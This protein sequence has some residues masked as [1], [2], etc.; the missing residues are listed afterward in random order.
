V[1]I[2]LVTRVEAAERAAPA[3][4]TVPQGPAVMGAPADHRGRRG[5]MGP[6]DARDLPAAPGA[7]GPTVTPG[8][9]A[10]PVATGPTA[11]P[12]A[13]GLSATTAPIETTGRAT[14]GPSALTAPSGTAAMSATAGP[15]AVTALTAPTALT[16]TAAMSATAG[17]SAVSAPTALTVRTVVT[18]LQGASGRTAATKPPVVETAP[19]A[20]PAPTVVRG[21]GVRLVEDV[22]IAMV[23]V[24]ARAAARTAHAATGPGTGP[25]TPAASAVTGPRSPASLLAPGSR[26]RRTSRRSPRGWTRA[27]CTAPSVPSCAACRRTWPRSSPRTWWSP[28]S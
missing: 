25:R 14:A 19:S 4:L 7:A 11:M 2:A 8:P 27:S 9:T 17:P 3:V 24:P 28:V 5:L 15:S 26:A 13:A 20:R 10:M 23:P 18:A 21:T 12:V 16:G 1:T 6:S 22:P